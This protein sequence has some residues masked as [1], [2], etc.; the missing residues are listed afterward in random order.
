ARCPV[1]VESHLLQVE[2]ALIQEDLGEAHRLLQSPLLVSKG[3]D[4]AVRYLHLVVKLKRKE[5]KAMILRQL[6]YLVRFSDHSARVNIG[7]HRHALQ[8][9]KSLDSVL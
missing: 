5:D 9:I 6:L 8:L 3:V 7:Y 1:C 2:A 4:F